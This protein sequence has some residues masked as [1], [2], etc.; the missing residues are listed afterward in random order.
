VYGYKF[1]RATKNFFLK[2]KRKKR[3]K[4]KT[5]FNPKTET[6]PDQKPTFAQKT[7]PDPDRSQ[8]V[9][10]AGLYCVPKF[11]LISGS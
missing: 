1:I 11:V 2:K 4:T 6:D 5:F 9:K 3:K 8:K 7:E 10:P